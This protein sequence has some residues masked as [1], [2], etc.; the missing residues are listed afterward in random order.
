MTHRNKLEKYRKQLLNQQRKALGYEAMLDF[1]YGYCSALMTNKLIT[2]KEFYML[3]R[4]FAE[5]DGN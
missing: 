4:E 1:C 5:N 3:R 2:K